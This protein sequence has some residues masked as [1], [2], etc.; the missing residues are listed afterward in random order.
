VR[1]YNLTSISAFGFLEGSLE[2]KVG[3]QLFSL[4]LRTHRQQFKMLLYKEGCW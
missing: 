4:A 3:R 1:A 2:R